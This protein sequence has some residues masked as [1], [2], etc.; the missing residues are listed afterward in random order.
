MTT[1]EDLER[2]AG[3]SVLTTLPPQFDRRVLQRLAAFSLELDRLV[4]LDGA[5]LKYHQ[6]SLAALVADGRF[7]PAGF[8]PRAMARIKAGAPDL[9]TDTAGLAAVPIAQLGQHIAGVVPLTLDHMSKAGVPTHPQLQDLNAFAVRSGV[10][11]GVLG[12]RG[13][14]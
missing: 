1:N 5:D 9:L 11:D 4:I 14:S 8:G 13:G 2:A 6:P 3:G 7:F 10:P 12:C